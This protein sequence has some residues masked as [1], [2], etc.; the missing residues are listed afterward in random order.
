[1]ID[2]IVNERADWGGKGKIGL[3]WEILNGL[4][5]KVEGSYNVAVMHR[6]YFEKNNYYNK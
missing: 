2:N 3:S 6:E 1:L 4:T 5:A